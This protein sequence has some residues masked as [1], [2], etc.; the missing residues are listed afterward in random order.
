M[1]GRIYR[2]IHTESDLCYIGS[3]SSELRFRWQGHRNGYSSWVNGKT[4][5]CSIYP[6]FKEHVIEKFRMILIKEYDV[7]DRKQLLA[8]EQLWINKFRKTSVNKVDTIDIKPFTK[9]RHAAAVNEHR[10]A[11]RDRSIAYSKQYYQENKAK[12]SA[13]SKERNKEKYNCDCGGVYSL[14]TKRQ[15]DKGK[16]HLKWFA[17]Q[18]Q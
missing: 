11:N 12:F 9:K 2:I 1:I 8:Y 4:S 18:D 17:E 6:H 5:P 13:Y 3:T 7:E 10:K 14:K 16:K 15:H